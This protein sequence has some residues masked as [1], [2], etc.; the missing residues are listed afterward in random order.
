MPRVCWEDVFLSQACP[1]LT[2][3]CIYLGKC[4]TCLFPII[5]V[6]PVKTFSQQFM[7]QSTAE[8]C[9]NGGPQS[10]NIKTA[11][12][13]CIVFAGLDYLEGH[14]LVNGDSWTDRGRVFIMR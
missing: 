4:S 8:C 5:R 6:C 13:Q 2:D 11:L 3:K 1:A 14:S 10:L 7:Y 12:G 9:F